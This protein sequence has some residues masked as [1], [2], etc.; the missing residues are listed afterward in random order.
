MRQKLIYFEN[1]LFFAIIWSDKNL[2]KILL[3][4]QQKS[5]VKTWQGGEVEGRQLEEPFYWHHDS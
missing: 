5:L 3:L 2:D 4:K 1:E